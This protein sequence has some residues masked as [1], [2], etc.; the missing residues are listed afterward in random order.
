MNTDIIVLAAI[1]IYMKL[2]SPHLVL[3]DSLNGNE[4]LELW[5]KDKDGGFKIKAVVLLKLY[6][7]LLPLQFCIPRCSLFF[8][9][10]TKYTQKLTATT[11]ETVPCLIIC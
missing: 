10:L 9:Y 6:T 7:F 8:F 1:C 5:D 4:D 11:K 2:V 3:I